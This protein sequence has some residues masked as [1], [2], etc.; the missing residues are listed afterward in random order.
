ME[1]IYLVL[2]S[3]IGVFLR[4]SVIKQDS[5][6]WSWQWLMLPILIG[7]PFSWYFDWPGIWP[8]PLEGYLLG[9]LVVLLIDYFDMWPMVAARQNPD[10]RRGAIVVRDKDVTQM[11]KRAKEAVSLCIGKVP[12]PVRVEPSHILA[13]GGTGTGKSLAITQLLDK[14]IERDDRAILAD[15]GGLYLSR[16][17]DPVRDRLLNPL[18]QRSVAWSPFAEMANPFDA[19]ALAKSLV[20]DGEGTAREWHQYCQ[21]LLSAIL[22]RCYETDQATNQK[23]L[24]FASVIGAEEL[25]TFVAGLPAA[26][27]AAE[28]NDKM[29]GSIR[30][31]LGSHLN[32]LIHLPP[33][34]G[35]EAFSIRKWIQSRSATRLYLPYAENQRATLKYLIAAW[36]DIASQAILSLA[37]DS[38][39]RI[40]LVADEVASI[41]R[42]QS[43]IDFLTNARKAGG[44]AIIGL[45]TISQLRALYGRDNAQTLLSCL[46][47]WCILRSNDPET[48]EYMSKYLGEEEIRR[49]NTGGGQSTGGQNVNWSE[50]IARQAV[51]LPSELQSLPDR[52]GFLKLPGAYPICRV[53]IPLPSDKSSGQKNFVMLGYPPIFMRDSTQA[54][55]EPAKVEPVIEINL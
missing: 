42:V 50:Q 52:Q 1:E 46:S 43:L 15:A 5:D 19:D 10:H 47:A 13:V 2:I 3:T 9:L 16:Y 54:A 45:Q 12:L 36:L 6:V 32:S 48:S 39:R 49:I 31:I 24:Y 53:E 11:I 28:G 18:D 22:Q 37:P 8:L 51:V 26:S 30:G 38:N 44:C 55:V 20:P 41:G 14:I 21:T 25:R 17:F 33:H 27:L 29:L 40:W 35:R 34:A 4:L 7:T 23:L